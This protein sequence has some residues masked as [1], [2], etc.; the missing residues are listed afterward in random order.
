[1]FYLLFLE[2][3]IR[4]RILLLGR[5]LR[6]GFLLQSFFVPQK[7]FSLQSLTQK[8]LNEKDILT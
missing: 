2:V 7:G 1:M 4:K 3:C 6:Q 5:C 8:N